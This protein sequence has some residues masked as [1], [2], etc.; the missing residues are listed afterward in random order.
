MLFSDQSD[1]L[2]GLDESWT[3]EKSDDD[4]FAPRASS[5]RSA[6]GSPKFPVGSLVRHPQFGVG[7]VITVTTG[8]NA[9]AAIQFKDVGV[10]TLVL[11]YARLERV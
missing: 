7:K 1:T 2:G 8:A 5:G 9:R 3:R 11:E 10:K 4:D 6:G